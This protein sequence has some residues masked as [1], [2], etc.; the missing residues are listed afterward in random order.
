MYK[1]L[2]WYY[3]SF[4]KGGTERIVALPHLTEEGTVLSCTSL[5]EGEISNPLGRYLFDAATILKDV[6]SEKG[7][8][9][10]FQMDHAL[11]SQ[12]IGQAEFYN[13]PLKPFLSQWIYSIKENQSEID[14]DSVG[15]ITNDALSFL[16]GNAKKTPSRLK[17]LFYQLCCNSLQTIKGAEI[18]QVNLSNITYTTESV[19]DVLD[20][21]LGL[22]G[23]S[24][25]L[26]EEIRLEFRPYMDNPDRFQ[27]KLKSWVTMNDSAFSPN[28]DVIFTLYFYKLNN[29]FDL[30]SASLQ[31]ITR[32]QKKYKRCDHCQ[33]LFV[34]SRSSG[35]YCTTSCLEAAKTLKKKSQD[36][37]KTLREEFKIDY[38]YIRGRLY[39]DD[40]QRKKFFSDLDRYEKEVARNESTKEDFQKW[41]TEK[42][43]EVSTTKYK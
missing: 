4:P 12:R 21:V 3:C 35:L 43:A 8:G 22:Y 20:T 40:E 36:T 2:S 38:D 14:I 23:I 13:S 25:D 29:F 27:S 37:Q 11:F 10:G 42:R 1:N 17:K 19:E 7:S 28:D 30:F 39:A 34:P 15:Y 41:L 31:E 16:S 18:V 26:Q 6:F 24:T 32:A 33:R 9:L 5:Y